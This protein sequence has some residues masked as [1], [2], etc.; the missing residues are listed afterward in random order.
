MRRWRALLGKDCLL[1]VELLSTL[2]SDCFR[3]VLKSAVEGEA[4]DSELETALTYA[5]A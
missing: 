4:A 3:R 5:I 2:S 1:E